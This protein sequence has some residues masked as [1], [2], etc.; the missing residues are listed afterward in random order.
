MD[1]A[2]G[3]RENECCGAGAREGRKGVRDKGGL[4]G[5]DGEEE[6]EERGRQAR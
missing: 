3:R 1:M 6:E 2:G 5:W 4:V